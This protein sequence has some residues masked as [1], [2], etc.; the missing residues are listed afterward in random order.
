MDAIS[1]V[2]NKERLKKAS[3]WSVRWK[4][5][6]DGEQVLANA[7]P[8]I[9]CRNLASKCGIKTIFYSNEEGTI[10][11][12]STDNIDSQLTAASAIHLRLQKGYKHVHFNRKLLTDDWN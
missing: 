8:C 5:N 1:K 3:L 7:K 12:S 2:K 9:Y 11:R 10:S 6:Q 4:I